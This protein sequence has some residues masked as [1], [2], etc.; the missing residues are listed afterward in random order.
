M[1]VL[2][3]KFSLFLKSVCVFAQTVVSGKCKKNKDGENQQFINNNLKLTIMNLSRNLQRII[4]IGIYF[5]FF[6]STNLICAQTLKTY[7]DD[8]TIYTYYKD[9]V[10]QEIKHGSYSSKYGKFGDLTDVITE[11][12]NYLHG[13]KDGLWTSREDIKTTIGDLT[14]RGFEKNTATFSSG[15]L[16]GPWNYKVNLSGVFYEFDYVKRVKKVSFKYKENLSLKMNFKNGV[17]C[18]YF[19]SN[20]SSYNVSFSAGLM[21]QNSLY[22]N[23]NGGIQSSFEGK[24]SG[25]FNDNGLMDGKWVMN[26]GKFI[27]Q[28]QN[29]VLINQA[30]LSLTSKGKYI[31]KEQDEEL[32]L[33]RRSFANKEISEEELKS[34]GYQID[35]STLFERCNDTYLIGRFGYDINCDIVNYGKYIFIS[36]VKQ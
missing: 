4:R 3:Y 35:T 14:K 13:K 34:K 1:K 36:K 17:V 29:G 7:S 9:S 24:V 19:E 23:T 11:K 27:A 28:F 12:G 5:L 31:D 32:T 21:Q 10:N 26:N 6:T 2:F 20:D 22:F 25:Q 18:G 15:K 8:G 16:N 30:E 33:I